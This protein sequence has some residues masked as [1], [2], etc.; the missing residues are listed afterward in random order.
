[1]TNKDTNKEHDW[2]TYTRSLL[3]NDYVPINVSTLPEPTEFDHVVINK[4]IQQHNQNCNTHLFDILS[5]TADIKE[6]NKI[7]FTKN[8][9]NGDKVYQHHKFKNYIKYIDM[10]ANLSPTDKTNP[11]TFKKIINYYVKHV[12]GD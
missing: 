7:P 9:T 12:I 5:T 10:V 2:T 6:I 4:K 3:G 1:M 8:N 11:A